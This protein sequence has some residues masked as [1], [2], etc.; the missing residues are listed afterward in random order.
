MPRVSDIEIILAVVPIV[1]SPGGSHV[2]HINRKR[3]KVPLLIGR[4]IILVNE[5][6]IRKCIH[7]IAYGSLH[8]I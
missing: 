7:R 3:T 2:V 8:V 5:P 4:K 6:W 1:R